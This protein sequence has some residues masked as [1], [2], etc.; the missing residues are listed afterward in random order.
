MGFILI[1]SYSSATKKVRP[2]VVILRV[3]LNTLKEAMWL[4][5]IRQVIILGQEAYES[6]V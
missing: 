2:S 1:L 3:I 4:M 5:D 6:V